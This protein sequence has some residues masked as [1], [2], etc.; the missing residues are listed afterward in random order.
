[1]HSVDPNEFRPRLEAL[2]TRLSAG[3]AGLVEEARHP[4][5]S[6]SSSGDADPGS[7]TSEEERARMLLGT[8]GNLLAEVNDALLRL[9]AG[10]FGKCE[11]CGTAIAKARLE[12]LPYA[13]H[14]IACARAA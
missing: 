11:K 14:C 9:Q 3:V 8:E 4:T 2:A 7:E 6:L 10:T 5:G 1:M 13:R 12:A